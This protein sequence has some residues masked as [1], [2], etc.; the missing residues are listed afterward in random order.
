M[1]EMPF[2]QA[3]KRQGGVEEQCK[4]RTILTGTDWKFH[5]EENWC[6]VFIVNP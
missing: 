6:S 1:F 5:L 3:G 2:T 4:R